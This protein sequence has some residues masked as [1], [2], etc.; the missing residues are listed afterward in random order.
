[1][2]PNALKI[3]AMSF[4]FSKPEGVVTIRNPRGRQ[5]IV[6]GAGAWRDGM[7]TLAPHSPC[8]VASGIWSDE[9]TFVI[10]LRFYE[11]PFVHTIACHF[12]GDRLTI[13]GAV[14]VSFGPT[15]YALTG[16]TQP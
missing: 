9:N 7:L 12:A 1:M 3:K 2:E 5:Q 6:C 11:T 10:T 8:A 13:D 14:N 4:D 16:Q 15:A